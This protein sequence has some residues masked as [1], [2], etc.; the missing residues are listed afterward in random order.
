MKTYAIGFISFFDNELK[1]SFAKANNALEAGITHLN[2]LNYEIGD[3]DG[4][5]EMED[6]KRFAFDMD[7]MIDVQELPSAV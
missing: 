1:V 4:I 5:A 2:G 6:L 3:G 7:C